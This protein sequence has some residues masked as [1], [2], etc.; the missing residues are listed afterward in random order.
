MAPAPSVSKARGVVVLVALIMTACGQA[1]DEQGDATSEPTRPAIELPSF[2]RLPTGG[3][4]PVT[5]E[6]PD[7]ILAAIVADA[8]ERTEVGRDGI[9]VLRAEAVTWSDGSLGC[10]QR[11]EVYP[12]TPVDGYH[13]VVDAAGEHLD[14]RVDEGGGYRICEQP[15]P[16]AGG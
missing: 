4:S 2:S 1:G 16:P 15:L 13:V 5:G 10:P 7:D 9:D 3:D 11:G 8:A 12:Q 14:Y 6:V